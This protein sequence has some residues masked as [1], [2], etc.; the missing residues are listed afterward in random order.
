MK[1]KLLIA[2]VGQLL[3]M[4]KPELVKKIADQVLDLVEDW[5]KDSSTEIDDTI[6]LPVCEM[7]RTTFDIPDND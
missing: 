1:Q 2:L 6:V 4:L 5:V 7:I 3:K